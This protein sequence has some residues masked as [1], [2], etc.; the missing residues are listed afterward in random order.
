MT[1][2]EIINRLK[3]NGYSNDMGE[4]QLR[5]YTDT[6]ERY[7]LVKGQ[8]KNRNSTGWGRGEYILIP[9]EKDERT[10]NDLLDGW[11]RLTEK[12]KNQYL[13]LEV[14]EGEWMVYDYNGENIGGNDHI[15]KAFTNR[16]HAH[17]TLQKIY[18]GCPG[19]GKSFSINEMIKKQMAGKQPD[20]ESLTP[21]ERVTLYDNY[22][23]SHGYKVNING[24][25]S[26]D[27][28]RVLTR[29]DDAAIAS[30][31]IGRDISSISELTSTDDIQKVI[32]YLENDEE[33]KKHNLKRCNGA[34]SCALKQ[35]K[36][37]L[38][39]DFSG[40]IFRVTFHPESDY[41]SFVGCFKPSMENG[42]IVYSYTTQAFTD[43]YIYAWTNKD[44]PTYLII[45]EINRGNCAAIFGDLFQLLDR[46]DGVS[47]YPIKAEKDLADHL[48]KCLSDKGS[49][50]IKE[51][52]LCLPDNLHIIA[53]MNTSDQGLFPMDSAF[54]RRW[55]WEYVPIKKGNKT[56]TIVTSSTF[57]KD[58]WDFIRE[59][60]KRIEAV[61]L[62][63]DK[64]IGFWFVKPK[65]DIIST[66][67]FV[68]KVISYLW[69]DIFK[70]VD[71]KSKENIFLFAE[72][73][74]DPTPH[75][76]DSF[77]DDTT[78]KINISRVESFIMGVMKDQVEPFINNDSTETDEEE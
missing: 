67:Y 63:S 22:L 70:N 58:W 46:K 60:N 7:S 2:E 56:Y 38:S 39:K 51:G 32:D 55:E 27:Y 16:V 26:N 15:E 35:Y 3:A 71:K 6:G 43:A 20:V 33:G 13:I 19:T 30:K 23:R 62:S 54:K 21:N 9:Y 68:S 76:F 57:Q 12:Y 73:A 37:L 69:N 8:V 50:G 11:R 25:V 49:D 17:D 52:L 61:T 5:H 36:N 41:S 45:E 4:T 10:I 40:N 66:E 75:T 59:V 14:S 28:P 24:K 31:A 34:P 47:E 53:T 65:D 74:G 44:V 1:K 64:K 48:S 18:F 42:R 77:F 78:G 29:A 72:E